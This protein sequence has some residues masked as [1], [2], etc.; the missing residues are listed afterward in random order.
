MS[1]A[2]F[3]RCHVCQA[4]IK[5]PMKMLGQIRPC[6]RCKQ[7]LLIR[8]TP[9]HDAPPVVVLPK[10]EPTREIPALQ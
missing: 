5:A 8:I 2:I 3:L 4:R 9:P 1:A 6:P 7:A 10:D